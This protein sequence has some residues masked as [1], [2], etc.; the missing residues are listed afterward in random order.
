MRRRRGSLASRTHRKSESRDESTDETA[1][2]RLVGEV[3]THLL[4]IDIEKSQ[5]SSKK[6][7]E[8]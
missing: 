8:D 7:S 1:P 2:H 6:K 4:S 3:M 5:L